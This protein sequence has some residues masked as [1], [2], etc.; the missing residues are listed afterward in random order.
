M[1][2]LS[3][4]PGLTFS[5]SVACLLCLA[6]GARV[7][8]A[9][10]GS[11][12]AGL[13]L[14]DPR[15]IAEGNALFA[16]SCSVGYCH[17]VAGKAGRGPRLR[18]RDWDKNYLFKVTFEG[19]PNS[20]MPAWKDR[21]TEAEIGAIVAYILTLSK[22][23]SNSVE[24]LP[25]ASPAASPPAAI[26]NT[27][28]ASPEPPVIDSGL[29][30]NPEK[31]KALFYDS[32]NDWNCGACHRIGGAGASVGPDLSAAKSK[33]VKD[34]FIDIVL[35]SASL[36]PDMPFL[37]ITTTTGEQIQAIKSEESPSHLKI[38]DIGS[39]PAVLRTLEKNQIQKLDTES[40]SAMP[41]KYGEMYT[42]KQ[43]L[44]IIAFLKAGGGGPSPAVSLNDL[45]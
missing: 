2:R 8:L 44:D 24:V 34:L 9:Q 26:S 40:R 30:G 6:L 7:T 20:S 28:V 10:T 37:K 16:Q 29:I 25:S 4:T 38:Y 19:V 17:G 41:A 35:P 23:S 43:L 42:V 39:L 14:S 1:R 3:S 32:S 21:L 36:S 45:R 15:V 5:S 18:G 33:A 31:G 12:P 11:L 27:P 13:D 22:L